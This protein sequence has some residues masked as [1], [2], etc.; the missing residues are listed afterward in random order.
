MTIA[1][2]EVLIEPSEFF[3]RRAPLTPL[4]PRNEPEFPADH[5]CTV[6]SSQID[7]EAFGCLGCLEYQPN[8]DQVVRSGGAAHTVFSALTNMIY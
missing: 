1:P 4:A 7:G 3:I 6:D 5:A 8:P 2:I